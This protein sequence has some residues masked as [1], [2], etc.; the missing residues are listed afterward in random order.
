MSYKRQVALEKIAL[1][2][3]ISELV[4]HDNQPDV[5]VHVPICY[6]HMDTAAQIGMQLLFNCSSQD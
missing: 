2:T 1:D 4:S 6:S 5:H 3:N